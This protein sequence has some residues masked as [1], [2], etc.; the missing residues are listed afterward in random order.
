MLQFCKKTNVEMLQQ[1]LVFSILHG[2][3]VMQCFESKQ[4]KKK[5]NFV[6]HFLLD[7][8]ILDCNVLNVTLCIIYYIFVSN[9]SGFL[10]LKYFI[11]RIIIVHSRTLYSSNVCMYTCVLQISWEKDHESREHFLVVVFLATR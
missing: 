8:V 2:N 11:S 7:L 9:V 3:T 10:M 4:L 6:F 5:K 1:H